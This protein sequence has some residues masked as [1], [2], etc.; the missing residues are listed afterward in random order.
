MTRPGRCSGPRCQ[1]AC[2]HRIAPGHGGLRLEDVDW[3][4]TTL[5]IVRP[6]TGVPTVLP[7]RPAVGRALATYPRRGRP[8]RT[9]ARTVFVS[10]RAPYGPLLGSSAVRHVLVKHAHAAGVRAQFLGSHAP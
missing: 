5:Q 8:R 7:L 6:K 10:A 4:A 9:A 3:R 2:G 1:R